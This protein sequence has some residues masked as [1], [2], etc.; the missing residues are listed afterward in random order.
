MSRSSV[1]D[2]VGT[3][4]SQHC[5]S[6]YHDT[7]KELKAQRETL[8]NMLLEQK[9]ENYELEMEYSQLEAEYRAFLAKLFKQA[10]QARDDCGYRTQ[11]RDYLVNHM[12][13][14]RK[15]QKNSKPFKQENS[16]FPSDPKVDG[17]Q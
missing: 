15:N 9:S 5:S 6:T 10:C 7:K 16:W 17:D 11:R 12:K 1:N 14:C 8:I 2:S 13:A 3:C 4:S